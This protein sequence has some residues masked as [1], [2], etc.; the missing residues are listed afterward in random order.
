MEL[1]E[2]THMP[3]YWRRRPFETDDFFV[4]DVVTEAALPAYAKNVRDLCD[5]INGIYNDPEVGLHRL[6]TDPK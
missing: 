5:A 3:L 4:V 1:R 6:A 2:R